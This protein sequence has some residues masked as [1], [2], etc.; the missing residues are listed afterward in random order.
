MLLGT[1]LTLIKNDFR[2]KKHVSRGYFALE[3]ITT[4]FRFRKV[5][6][7]IEKMQYHVDRKIILS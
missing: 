4:L 7:W 1:E 6:R 5:L 3:M 2:I